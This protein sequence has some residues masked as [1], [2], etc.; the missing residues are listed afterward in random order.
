MT[1]RHVRLPYAHVKMA[2]V[3]CCIE[4]KTQATQVLVRRSANDSPGYIGEWV[5]K[6]GLAAEIL[7]AG[8]SRRKL[9]T[10]V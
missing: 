4:H 8:D 10:L 6:L 2:T 3:V 1:S 9:V 7:I 5:P